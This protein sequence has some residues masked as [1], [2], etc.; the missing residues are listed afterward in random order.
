[1]TQS[2]ETPLRFDDVATDPPRL[3]PLDAAMDLV[4]FAITTWAVEPRRVRSYVPERFDLDSREIDS[5]P[6]AF[7][8]M[9][10]Y[11][12]DRLR[13][14]VAPF[15]RLSFAQTNYRVYV[16]DR[17]SGQRCVWFLGFTIDARVLAPA[18]K[19]IGVPVTRGH[20]RIEASL[21]ASAEPTYRVVTTAPGHN[22]EL[23]LAGR[24]TT[25]M[26]GFPDTETGVVSLSHESVGFYPR[27]RGGHRRVRVWHPPMCPIS[28]A[29]VS[30]RIQP[31]HETGIVP[32]HRQNE[33][34][35]VLIQARLEFVALGPWPGRR[36]A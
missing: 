11:R 20:T 4:D 27:P 28:L 24:V 16:V 9:V 1:M 21:A 34:H 3:R 18:A 22:A 2:A 29:A 36:S 33:P 13:L 15:V 14:H 10:T 31:L 8:S 5:E 30:A 19:L 7:V 6:F 35:S 23:T 25:T 12:Y 26:A 32:L 17:A